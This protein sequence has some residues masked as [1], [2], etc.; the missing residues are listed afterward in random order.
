MSDHFQRLKTALANRYAVVEELGAGGMATVYLAEDLKH[1]RKVAVKVLR[2]ELTAILGGDRFLK[3]IEVTANLQH[4][5]ILPLYDSGE[6]NA[7]LY[8]VMP[9]VEGESLRDKLVREKQLAVHEAVEIGKSVAAA[10]DY[11]H[12]HEV[13]HRDIKPEN[14]LLHDGQARV[15]DFGIAL[16][17]SAAGGTRLTETGLSVGT[18]HYMSPEQ[19]SADRELDGRSDVYSLGATIYEMLAG[20]PPFEA[21]S[22]QAI[23]AK[24]LTEPPQRLTAERATVPRNVE[25]AV[26]KAL[27]KLPADRFASAA[28]FAHALSDPAWVSTG[29]LYATARSRPGVESWSGASVTRRVALAAA[30]VGLVAIGIGVGR[31]TRPAAGERVQ[32]FDIALPDEAPLDFATSTP[33]GD[34]RTAIAID[35]QGR[36]VVY[37]GV[38]DSTTQLYLHELN[39]FETTALPETEGA[40]QPIFSPD[41]QSVAFFVGWELRRISLGNLAVAVLG[42]VERQTEV[43]WRSV[44]RLLA[45]D[46]SG[47]GGLGGNPVSYLSMSWIAAGGGAVVDV[48]TGS[49][50]DVQAGFRHPCSRMDLLP[51]EETVLCSSAN[52]YLIAVDLADGSYH[53][54][55]HPTGEGGEAA[56]PL[57][58]SDPRYLPGGYL[59]YLD[60][61]GT[62]LVSRFD[63]DRLILRSSPVP[64]LAQ[65]QREG[66]GMA[67]QFDVAANGTLIYVDGAN[68]PKGHFV[69]AEPGRPVDSLPLPPAEYSRFD[70]SANGQVLAAVTEGPLGEEL[71]I[72]DLSQ[73]TPSSRRLVADAWHI[74][75]PILTPT[76]DRVAFQVWER[77]ADKQVRLLAYT[78]RNELPDTMP[79]G[80]GLQSVARDG[81][82]WGVVNGNIAALAVGEDSPIVHADLPGT[83]NSPDV[84]PD[85]R[86][87]AYTSASEVYVEPLPRTGRQY[88]ASRAEGGTALWT[89]PR[90]LVYVEGVRTFYAVHLD[91]DSERTTSAPRFLYY[92]PR[93][94]DTS[95][96]SNDVAPD[97]RLLYLRR[98]PET[99]KRHIRVIANWLDEVERLTSGGN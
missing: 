22:A 43:V 40:Y 50:A 55:T 16:A 5:N 91:P 31:A 76:G 10:L 84:S 3:E 4:P 88:R 74:N 66:L 34:G 47:A 24:I 33:W 89:G 46:Q 6:A 18:P 41:G 85:G 38:R 19:A 13:V 20:R 70:L 65:V 30:A 82:F 2:P 17:V 51:S 83:Q 29:E 8:Y 62:L 54:L 96:R 37:V 25:A 97:G 9:F 36:R 56:A 23:V 68:A 39:T 21:S 64:A 78:V 79:D 67:G 32:R 93:F 26:D 73:S 60:F 1:H 87:L 90:D 58:G 80:F 42:D 99:P 98:A 12:R 44:D 49:L 59:A 57:R 71:W 86:W 72:H 45:T 14:I 11:A 94:L 92:D 53:V 35:P 15:A 48:P 81:T 28:D 27:A 75:Q 52:G 95:G 63:A 77:G 69:L 7:F 61:E